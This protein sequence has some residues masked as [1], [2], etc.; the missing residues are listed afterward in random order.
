[1]AG[2]FAVLW[3]SVRRF[4]ALSSLTAPA[5]ATVEADF[6]IIYNP[7]LPTCQAQALLQQLTSFAGMPLPMIH[8]NDDAG[9][10][11]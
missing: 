5:L 6:R 10:C 3:R 8:D 1:M 2:S 11:E 7:A 9:T 4:Y